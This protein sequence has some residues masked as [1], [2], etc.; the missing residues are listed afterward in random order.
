M[1]FT[2][3]TKR[4]VKRYISYNYT[5]PASSFRPKDRQRSMKAGRLIIPLAVRES[6]GDW[7]SIYSNNDF[8]QMKHI[9]F[10]LNM[11]IKCEIQIGINCDNDVI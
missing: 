9:D 3:D 2:T 8:I 1:I 5:Q 7:G 10:M 6:E 11:L 4:Q